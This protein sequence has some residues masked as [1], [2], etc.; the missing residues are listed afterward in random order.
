MTSNNNDTKSAEYSGF[1]L[2]KHPRGREKG[3]A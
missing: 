3:E 2:V 1:L